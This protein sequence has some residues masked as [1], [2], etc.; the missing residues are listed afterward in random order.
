MKIRKINKRAEDKDTFYLAFSLTNADVRR[1][2]TEDLDYM[3]DEAL[4]R[5]FW[6]DVLGAFLTNFGPQRK[7]LSIADAVGVWAFDLALRYKYPVPDIEENRFL[8]N[9]KIL[10]VS[11][12]GPKPQSEEYE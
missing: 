6:T 5:D 12:P 3:T 10:A 8:I 7:R 11:K 1:L 9:E 2:L 4:P